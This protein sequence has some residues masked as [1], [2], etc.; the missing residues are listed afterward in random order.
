MIATGSRLPDVQLHRVGESGVEGVSL[1]TLA[2]GRRMIL[3]GVPGAFTPTCS[4][5]HLPGYIER[6]E[7]LRSQGIEL[8]ACVAVNDPYV[9]QA[10][11][12]AQGVGE[13][14]QMLADGN[15]DFARAAGIER[16]F[17]G[18]GMGMRNRR[19]ALIAEDG[20]VTA[21]AIEPARGIT[22]CGAADMLELLRREAAR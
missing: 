4:N 11:G 22:V 18:S 13:S 2:A 16:D 14:I 3:F 1:A 9:M 12:A 17:S 6:L 5:E 19:F 15:G 7:E 10:W 8:V 21:L 20:L